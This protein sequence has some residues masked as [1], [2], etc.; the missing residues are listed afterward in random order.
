MTPKVSEEAESLIDRDRGRGSGQG[1]VGVSPFL[2]KVFE[3]TRDCPCYNRVS[4]EVST[5][6]TRPRKRTQN[7]FDPDSEWSRVNERE[8]S[9]ASR[10]EDEEEWTGWN[11]VQRLET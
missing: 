7:V 2:Q 8:G 11:P 4:K 1:G 6:W 5:L 10:L 9:G 3:E